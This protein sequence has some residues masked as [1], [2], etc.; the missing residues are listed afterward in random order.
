MKEFNVMY[1]IGKVKYVINTHNGIDT[2][3]DGSK[4]FGI[5]TFKNKKEFI[6]KQKELIKQGYLSK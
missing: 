3:K 4:F 2:H 5:E 1:N 6:A